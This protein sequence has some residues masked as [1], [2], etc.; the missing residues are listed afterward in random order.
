MFLQ[1]SR[2]KG[3]DHKDLLRSDHLQGIHHYSCQHH[4]HDF[5]DAISNRNADPAADLIAWI[6]QCSHCDRKQLTMLVQKSCLYPSWPIGPQATIVARTET[7]NHRPTRP[8][9]I[10]QRKRCFLMLVL[11]SRRHSRMTATLVKAMVRKKKTL[12]AMATYY[13]RQYVSLPYGV[14]RMRTAPMVSAW[15]GDMSAYTLPNPCL[16]LTK[17]RI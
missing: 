12:P 13:A 5:E 16:M 17:I 15:E 3:H 10:S 1:E 14:L 11:K 2:S 6:R 8:E 9:A 4:K 7:I